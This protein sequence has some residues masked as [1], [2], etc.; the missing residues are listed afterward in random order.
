MQHKIAASRGDTAKGRES[1]Y[2]EIFQNDYPSLLKL[3]E[4]ISASADLVEGEIVRDRR[5]RSRERIFNGVMFL[6]G[7]AGAIDLFIKYVLHHS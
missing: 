6:F 5:S 1:I 7:L 3:F 2:E 4:Q